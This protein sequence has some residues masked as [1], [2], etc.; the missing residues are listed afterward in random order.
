MYVYI[1]TYVY[2]YVYIYVFMHV[3]IYLATL[4]IRCHWISNA[5]LLALP[6]THRA[7]DTKVCHPYKL[8]ESEDEPASVQLTLSLWIANAQVVMKR[9]RVGWPE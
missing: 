9:S 5:P 6:Y 3:C 4:V 7:R 8:S 2:I 1:Y